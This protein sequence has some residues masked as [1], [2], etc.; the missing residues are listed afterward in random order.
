MITFIKN[1][2]FNL[3]NY[4]EKKYAN[5]IK[6]F[7]VIK[8]LSKLKENINMASSKKK[9]AILG[10]GIVGLA[11]AYRLTEVL[12]EFDITIIADSFGVETT[13]DGA[14]GIFRPDDRFMQG[15]PKETARLFFFLFLSL[16]V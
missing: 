16:K 11:T 3:T 13:S 8:G 9:Y 12:K 6:I 2:K 14:G 4:N 10:A 5:F 1:N 15:I 7:F